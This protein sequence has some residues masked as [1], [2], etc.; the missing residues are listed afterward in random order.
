ME[1]QAGRGLQGTID[2]TVWGFSVREWL[3]VS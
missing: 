1:L 3:A 2:V